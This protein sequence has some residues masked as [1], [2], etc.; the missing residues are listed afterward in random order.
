[1]NNKKFRCSA[2]RRLIYSMRPRSGPEKHER[3]DIKFTEKEKTEKFIREIL[4]GTDGKSLRNAWEKIRADNEIRKEEV[5]EFANAIIAE[6]ASGG[7]VTGASAF[8]TIR[9][10][11]PTEP[12]H[13][14]ELAVATGLTSIDA[15]VRMELVR[16]RGHQ[17]KS[18]TPTPNSKDYWGGEWKWDKPR[19]RKI[20]KK[21]PGPTNYEKY[22]NHC[23]VKQIRNIDLELRQVERLGKRQRG[24]SAFARRRMYQCNMRKEQLRH[25]R[26]KLVRQF[27]EETGV[28]YGAVTLRRHQSD[29]R[30]RK[31][32]EDKRNG[33]TRGPVRD[34]RGRTAQEVREML[35]AQRASASRS[36]RSSSSREASAW[37]GSRGLDAAEVVAY[38]GDAAGLYAA[39]T[40]RR[41]AFERNRAVDYLTGSRSDWKYGGPTRPMSTY[42]DRTGGPKRYQGGS[43]LDKYK[44][45]SERARNVSGQIRS[46]E[47]SDKLSSGYYDQFRGVPAYSGFMGNLNM[48]QRYWRTNRDRIPGDLMRLRAM[49]GE[50]QRQLT[51]QR[52]NERAYQEMEVARQSGEMAVFHTEKLYPVGGFNKS[53]YLRI[54]YHD[55]GGRKRTYKYHPASA[56]SEMNAYGSSE[57]AT[58]ELL[59]LGIVIKKVPYES[60]YYDPH[61]RHHKKIKGVEIYFRKPGNFSVH[62]PGFNRNI[63]VRQERDYVRAGTRGIE[64]VA[65]EPYTKT[66]PS[67]HWD[68]ELVPNDERQFKN[69]R[70][71]YSVDFNKKKG[72]RPGAFLVKRLGKGGSQETA[73]L[74]SFNVPQRNYREFSV[75]PDPANP[76][77][78]DIGFFKPG[79]Y[80]VIAAEK[81]G[82]QL[83]RKV[84]TVKEK[85]GDKPGQPTQYASREERLNEM[86]WF[87]KEYKEIKARAK[88]VLAGIKNVDKPLYKELKDLIGELA[89]IQPSKTPANFAFKIANAPRRFNKALKRFRMA[90]LTTRWHMSAVDLKLAGADYSIFEQ[91]KEHVAWTFKTL[92]DRIEAEVK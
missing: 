12:K 25:H 24:R 41:R 46:E 67:Y 68:A 92:L 70:E 40:E 76:K 45:S 43:W 58:E 84:I 78:F 65:P 15:L 2:E 71:K 38:G 11:L 10:H 18:H 56:R 1:M 51:N 66:A 13:V 48:F 9:R 28:M 60:A 3:E 32:A 14:K 72:F 44:A 7:K 82:M 83:E 21:K 89:Y 39:R 86:D 6:A 64:D 8:E 5:E 34:A 27:H 42:I 30:I 22:K 52:M 17:Q 90:P 19:E 16:Q 33:V 61:D 81:S 35:L 69:A 91:K 55:A 47:L 26:V 50:L 4:K 85:P 79:T 49:E 73:N 77:K 31:R 80:E 53:A 62:G 57:V 88:E 63:T 37:D 75:Y 87:E 59:D 29:L 23:L 20:P 54:S 36:S 74:M